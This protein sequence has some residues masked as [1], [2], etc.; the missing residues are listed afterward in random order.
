MT[1]PRSYFPVDVDQIELHVFGDSSQEVFSAVAFLRGNLFLSFVI[2]KSRVAPMKLLTVP[3]MEQQ[4]ALL[5]ARL[6][7][8]IHEAFN[9][10]IDNIFLGSK[11]FAM[12][13]IYC[14]ATHLDFGQ[15]LRNFR[16]DNQKP[17][18]LC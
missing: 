8:E 17:V 18:E 7:A 4:A 6:C 10:L 3:K 9:C 16:T 2:R 1:I 14:K 15:S 13:A 5:A 11:N 12:V